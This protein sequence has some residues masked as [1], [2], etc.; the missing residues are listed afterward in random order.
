MEFSLQ[1]YMPYLLNRAA[2][3]VADSFTEEIRRFDLTITMWRTMAALHHNGAMRLGELAAA[4]SI[5]LSTLSRLITT[6]QARN[7]VTRTRCAEDARAVEVDLTPGGRRTTEEIIPIALGYERTSLDGFTEEEAAQLR[8]LL[9]RLFKNME[10]LSGVAVS[11]TP[12]DAD[13]SLR[14][15]GDRRAS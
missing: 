12:P 3:R 1:D 8:G 2:T 4:T 14:S 11:D 7:L 6:M 10:M 13:A 9:R 5:E 15:E